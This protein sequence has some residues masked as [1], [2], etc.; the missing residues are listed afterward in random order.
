MSE[1]RD[2]RDDADVETSTDAYAGR[3]SGPVGAWFLEVQAR[4]V[5]E[6]LA[7]WPRARVLDVGGGHAQIAPLL[8]ER[9]HAVTV[10]GST[11]AC[12]VRLDRI[13]A[14]GAY[15][16]QQAALPMLPF[17]DRDFDVVLALR[18]LPHAVRWRELLAEMA[19]V[20]RCA[21]V[22]D[23]PDARSANALAG[24]LFGLKR[25]AEGN[26]RR[27]RLFRRAD[28]VAELGRH[29]LGRP[30]IRPQFLLPMMLHRLGGRPR[31]SRPVEG[32]FRVVGATRAFGSPVLL[33]VQR[34]TAAP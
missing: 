8:I 15:R 5:L 28:L 18:L 21:V 19:R 23:Y 6:L 9:G 16:F 29:G 27:F 30:A 12:R 25:K 32:F 14:P 13:L 3:F 2:F 24:L 10:V 4:A 34:D 33:R 1:R 22:V 20:A 17:P 11:P 31:W 26:P 7:P